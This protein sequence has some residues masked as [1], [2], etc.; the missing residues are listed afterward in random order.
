MK[1]KNILFAV[2]M[3]LT[4][5]FASCSKE[6]PRPSDPVPTE[7]TL[8]IYM[9]WSTNLT[10]YFES[11]LNDFET[12]IRSGILGNNRVVVFFASSPTEARLFEL[13]SKN[14]K[15]SREEIKIYKN[16]DFT[17][18][19]CI[20][21]ILDDVVDAA[22]AAKYSMVVGCHG[23]GWLPAGVTLTR[24]GAAEKFHWDYEGGLPTRFFGGLTEEF[25]IDITAFAEGI[26]NAGLM[27]EYILFDDC[28]MSSIE[29][30]YDLRGVTKH[31]IASPTEIMAY[32]FPYKIIAGDLLTNDY[33]GICNGFYEFYQTYKDP[34][35][36]VGLIDCS[37]LDGLA[38]V[39]REIN[40]RFTFD[41]ALR[42]SVQRM[43]G[44]NP[45][46]FFDYG[47]YV[48]KLCTDPALLARF[49]AQLGRAV[50]EIYRLHTRSFYSMIR[51]PVEIG[52]Y[53]GVTI[54]DPS[55][56]HWAEAYKPETAWYSAT[57]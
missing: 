57:H 6:M 53:T 28:Y 13:K 40:R 51:G 4:A 21:S 16:P 45:V 44:Y 52:A 18:A 11:N 32:G 19:D 25:Q 49:E 23:M 8:F 56:H 55:V 48:K 29:V 9:P 50:P 42:G 31:L 54:S 27:M 12:A 34:Y 7:Q 43:D 24:R 36:T 10:P 20:T 33:Q 5:L 26:A 17:T 22:P 14:G 15:N 38:T 35:A 1:A 46:V 3:L 47:D 39:M 41:P 30:A 37:E 2:L